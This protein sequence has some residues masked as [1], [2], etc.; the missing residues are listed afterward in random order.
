VLLVSDQANGTAGFQEVLMAHHGKP[1]R[2][3][4]RREW[5]PEAAFLDW[6]GR[7]VFKGE[8]RHRAAG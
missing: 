1:V 4:Q 6:H 5:K 3:S 8:A 7:E 2:P